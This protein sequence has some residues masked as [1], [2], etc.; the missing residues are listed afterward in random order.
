MNE[1]FFLSLSNCYPFFFFFFFLICVSFFYHV[2]IER[3]LIVI[4]KFYLNEIYY[5]LSKIF[6]SFFSIMHA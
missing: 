3:K 1:G 5:Y 2:R 4:L 6:I